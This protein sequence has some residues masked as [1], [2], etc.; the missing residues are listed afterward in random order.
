MSSLKEV[1]HWGYLEKQLVSSK[2]LL[3]TNKVIPGTNRPCIALFPGQ[4]ACSETALMAVN[5]LE[6]SLLV[7]RT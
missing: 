4:G 7:L 3:S 2:W 5:V 6:S 1:M